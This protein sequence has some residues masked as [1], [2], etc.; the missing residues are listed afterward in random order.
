[1]TGQKTR[2]KLYHPTTVQNAYLEFSSSPLGQRTST[3]PLYPTMDSFDLH[4]RRA[5]R[6]EL[7]ENHYN[8]LYGEEKQEKSPCLKFAR[9][10]GL[11]NLQAQ[12]QPRFQHEEVIVY[13]WISF[14]QSA[15]ASVSYPC[16]AKLE[17]SFVTTR[18]VPATVLSRH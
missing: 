1:M 3:D 2:S 17:K 9:G 7:M 12:T 8:I 13:F 11:R 16:C 5:I 14:R 18:A 4:V 6:Q 15:V 10:I